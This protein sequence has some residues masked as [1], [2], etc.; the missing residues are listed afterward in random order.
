M[1]KLTFLGMLC[2][3]L[4]PP[5]LPSSPQTQDPVLVG[6]G[7]IA[8]CRSGALLNAQATANLLD[9]ITGTVFTAG[10][11]AYPDGSDGNFAECYDLTWGRH[12]ARTMPAVGNHEYNALDATDYYS[13]F[14][15]VAGTPR[16]GYYSYDLGT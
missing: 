4:F 1:R 14:G 6:A 9:S 13:Y 10:D 16:Q 2:I 7:D 12:R 5:S 8:D 11:D 15:P 3:F